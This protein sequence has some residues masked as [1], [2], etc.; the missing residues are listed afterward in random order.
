MSS[1]Q[2]RPSAPSRIL[3]SLEEMQ[4]L[5]ARLKE[6]RRLLQVQFRLLNQRNRLSGR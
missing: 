1:S 4:T 6:V 2:Y 3:E 5:Q